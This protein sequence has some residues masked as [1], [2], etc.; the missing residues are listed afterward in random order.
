MQ[1][2]LSC[3][4]TLPNSISKNNNKDDG[5]VNYSNL[6]RQINKSNNLDTLSKATTTTASASTALASSIFVKKYD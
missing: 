3:K 1:N 5:T 2:P 6:E 4:I